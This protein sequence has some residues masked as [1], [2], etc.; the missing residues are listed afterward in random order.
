MN[1]HSYSLA[2]EAPQGVWGGFEYVEPSFPMA[3]CRTITITPQVRALD[4]AKQ[5]VKP[6]DW[7]IKASLNVRNLVPAKVA[8]VKAAKV[9][10]CR[11]VRVARVKAPRKPRPILTRQCP[12]CPRKMH[13]KRWETC[14]VCRRAAEKAERLARPAKLCGAGCGREIGRGKMCKR[15]SALAWK[16]AWRTAHR[17]E[18]VAPLCVCGRRMA[19]GKAQRADGVCSKCADKSNQ[20]WRDLAYTNCRL[21]PKRV[22]KGMKT[23][24]CSQ[25]FGHER[26]R[27]YWEAKET[28]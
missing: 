27:L 21:C 26:S 25:R 7:T 17:K 11:P 20:R 4:A 10:V 18:I 28:A 2:I 23:G 12:T 3:P 22:R 8:P 6:S 14:C 9:V 19:R 5:V 13:T 16:R 15:C 24:L 1:F